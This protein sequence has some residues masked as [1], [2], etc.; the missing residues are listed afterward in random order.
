MT[1]EASYEMSNVRVLHGISEMT[2]DAVYRLYTADDMLC[3]V[4]EII[5]MANDTVYCFM[6]CADHHRIYACSCNTVHCVQ[7]QAS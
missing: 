2:N 4:N 6:L 5:E 7:A 3:S 1:Y